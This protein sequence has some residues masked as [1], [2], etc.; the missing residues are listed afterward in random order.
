MA[1]GSF[2]HTKEWFK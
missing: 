1:E 2:F